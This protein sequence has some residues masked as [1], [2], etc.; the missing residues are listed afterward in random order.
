M[1]SF[2]SA[3]VLGLKIHQTDK[4]IQ[5]KTKIKTI[6]LCSSSGRKHQ[7]PEPLFLL[8][9]SVT[10]QFLNFPRGPWS[11]SDY[12]HSTALSTLND[13]YGHFVSFFSFFSFFPDHTWGG[14]NLSVSVFTK[15]NLAAGG[16]QS[17]KT[18]SGLW[19][20]ERLLSIPPLHPLLKI[21]FSM[22]SRYPLAF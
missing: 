6:A 16:A 8:C 18:N 15:S 19:G 3:F 9:L 2:S 1:K 4:T 11:W 21:V 7:H 10:K 14:K 13:Q 22:S 17:A 20:G 5:K 12:K